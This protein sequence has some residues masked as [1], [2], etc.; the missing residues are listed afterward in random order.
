VPLADD[1]GTQAGRGADHPLASSRQASP[2]GGGATWPSRQLHPVCIIAVFT[3]VVPTR[4][5]KARPA[6]T[7][8]E[9]PAAA[10][11]PPRVAWP[12]AALATLHCLTGC[13]IGEILGMVIG[14][15]VGLPNM[16]TVVLAVALAFVFGY[17][18]TARGLLRAGV[19]LAAALRAA[20]AADT[21]S[22]AVMELLDNRSL[23]RYPVP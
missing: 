14:T 12:G 20:L 8:S 11:G 6:G 10:G 2:V 23:P 9:A 4:E 17:G 22:I 21:A 15:A 16:P 1:S 19:G 13:A 3:S 7:A 5:I 18:L